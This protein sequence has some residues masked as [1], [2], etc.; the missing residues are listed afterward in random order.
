MT[1]FIFLAIPLSH[2]QAT[3]LHLWQVPDPRWPQDTRARS[4]VQ[5]LRRDAAGRHVEIGASPD[6]EPI[7]T[8]YGARYRL[9]NWEPMRHKPLTGNFDYY[10]LDHHDAALVAERH[11]QVIYRGVGQTI[12]VCRL[13][14]CLASKP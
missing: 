12:A 3:S 13:S 4:L 7:L 6:L 11:L 8:F 2:A 14:T 10:V 5:A 1:G 9:S